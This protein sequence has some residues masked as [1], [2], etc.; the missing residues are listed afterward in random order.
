[1][2]VVR[3]FSLLAT[4]SSLGIA[5]LLGTVSRRPTMSRGAATQLAAA[6]SYYD[7]TIVLA[8][9][10]RP[11]GIRGDELTI[12]LGY[13]ERL[14]VGLASPFRLVD[15]ALSDP[16]LDSATGSRV[17]W[18]LLARLRRGDAYV[19]DPQVLDGS[20]PWSADGRGA[21]GAAHLALIEQAVRSASDPRAGELA[22]RLAYL[23]ASAKG[24]IT[25]SSVSIATR[26]AALVRDRE[27]ASADLG[28]LLADASGSHGDVMSMLSDRRDARAFRVEQPP[29]APLT[30]S[31]RVEAMTAVSRL[32][33]AL[34]TLDRASVPPPATTAAWSL[35]SP[36]FAAR[37][38]EL[39]EDRPP[40]AQIAVTLRTHT[41]SGIRAENDETLAAEYAL[42]AGGPD[43][44]HRSGELALLA[45]AVAVRS[46]AQAAPWFP[47]DGGPEVADLKAEFGLA[48]VSFS[49]GV[50]GAWR[51]Y[52]LRELR[53]GLRD[54]RRVL[55]ALA[56]DELRV[57]FGADALPDSAL[58]LH[59]PRTRTLQLSIATSGGTLAHELSHDLD[60]QEARRLFVHAG[61]Y[62][63]D[64][65]MRDQR[66]PLAR[67]MRGLTEARPLGAT[68]TGGAPPSV[69]RPAEVFARGADWFIASSLAAQGRIDGFLS[70]IEDDMLAGYA[71]GQPV[72]IGISGATS[73]TA[74][75][76][77]MT[78]LPDSV[79]DP[80]ESQWSNAAVVDPVLLVRRVLETP[81]A[82]RAVWQSRTGAGALLPPVQSAVCVGDDSPESRARERL[83]MLAVDARARGVA[84]RR[85]R[86]R[87]ASMRADWANSVLRTAPWSPDE[88]ERLIDGLRSAILDQIATTL[89]NQG[90]VLAV[91]AIFASNAASCSS[92]AR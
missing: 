77:Q 73:L 85:A 90:L 13:L 86:F 40:V 87:P 24:T 75:I 65:V 46:L 41:P 81:V 35:L 36:P 17:A 5:A 89:S 56:F 63:T 92:M 37:L 32:V 82:W 62:S 78:Y 38:R 27:S 45:S 79:R 51:P 6:T 2:D 47:G 22:V 61:G 9:N 26:V 64:R 52:Y 33:R 50:R 3:R 49:H 57:R 34:D 76:D 74:T 48:D 54:M 71:A 18:A 16:R 66:G 21:T 58:A 44:I 42:T 60:W 1:M 88:G 15:E 19:I 28:E 68:A 69:D 10:A 84:S 29:L 53:D 23:I 91:P 55:P 31:L 7:S 12:S 39:G 83:L 72:A 8:R 14:R 11:R 59:D 43:S 20:G 67:S 30:A 70:A 4:A 80:F 25:P